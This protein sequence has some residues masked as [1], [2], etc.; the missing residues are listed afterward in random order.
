LRVRRLLLLLLL[1]IAPLAASCGSR[2][3]VAAG[4]PGKVTNSVTN[5][6]AN[7]VTNSVTNSVAVTLPTTA[8]NPADGAVT[9]SSTAANPVSSTESSATSSTASTDIDKLGNLCAAAKVY[10]INDLTTL[11]QNLVTDP[12]SFL[13]AYNVIVAYIPP[14]DADLVATLGPFTNTVVDA[15]KA[16]HM[17]KPE[18]VQAWLAADPKRD[19]LE[20]WISAQQKLAPVIKALCF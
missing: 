3:D 15:V 13:G 5:S 20:A 11:A 12:D 17:T 6:V 7:S 14:E 1:A 2:V 18:E 16:S 4:Q 19:G 8:A 10:S 9:T